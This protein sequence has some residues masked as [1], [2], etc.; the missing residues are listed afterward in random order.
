MPC[1][2]QK[3]YQ[4]RRKK[5]ILCQPFLHFSNCSFCAIILLVNNL[6]IIKEENKTTLL[7]AKYFNLDR[8][9]DCGQAFRWV[10]DQN[11]FWQGIVKGKFLRAKQD[12]DTIT[13]YTTKKDFE[14]LWYD[15]FDLNSNYQEICKL[16]SK[17]PV[18]NTALKYGKGIRVLNQE[19]FEALCSFIISQNN[20]IPR[21]KGIIERLCENFG[22]KH[23]FGYAFPTPERIAKS[24][25]EELSVLRSGFR[26]KYL[27][28]A[29][30]KVYSGE[31]DL[32][33]L[34]KL[35]IDAARDEL[36]KIYGVG[37]KVADCTM[38]F[39][40][41]KKEAF[42]EDVWIKRA[43]KVLF[44]GEFPKEL[45]SVKGVAQQFLFYYARSTKLDI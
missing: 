2:R 15:Y 3:S 29:A 31:I 38:L 40:L 30:K 4:Q 1:F 35:P 11:G 16:I 42:P 19:P 7:N 32:D 9:L 45:D 25:L 22:E 39:S 20:N 28:D 27:L 23:P 18:L 26:A 6:K 24:S 12:G 36:T 41:N 5:A 44:G 14:E 37:K 21:I 17:D 43:V 8:T 10:K 33:A 13:L 34:K